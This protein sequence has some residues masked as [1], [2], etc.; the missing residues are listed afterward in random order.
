[1][2]TLLTYGVAALGGG[3]GTVARLAFSRLVPE[4]IL[5]PFPLPILAVNV[6]GCFVMG[7]FAEIMATAYAF[8][9]HVR[10]FLT[11]GFLGGFTTF[12]AFSMECFLLLE[13]GQIGAAV[14]YGAV[15]FFLTLMAF[16]VGMGLI[17]LCV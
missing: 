8:N 7:L 5:I 16:F 10:T 9:H 13:R 15:T 11:V 2:T 6:V 14:L 4:S 3:L 12:S 1:M 17:R